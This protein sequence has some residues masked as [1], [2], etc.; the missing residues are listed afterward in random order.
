MQLFYAEG[1]QPTDSIFT[2]SKIESRHITQALRKRVGEKICITNGKGYLF[3]GILE[4][5]MRSEPCRVRI[6]SSKQ[7]PLQAHAMLHIAIA[8]TQSSTRNEWLIEKATELGME[9]LSLVLC[10]YSERKYINLDRMSRIAVAA[11]KQSLQYHLPKL[12]G[13]Q[14]LQSFLEKT[15]EPIKYIATLHDTH[16]IPIHGA[17]SQPQSTCV[18]IGP[19]GGFTK[20]ELIMCQKQG[21]QGLTLTPQRLRTETAALFV[22]SQWA[23]QKT[24]FK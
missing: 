3:E 4:I 15:R 1:L 18:L 16:K 14:D 10:R 23:A 17:F 20:E 7:M 9:K 12:Q 19:E 13:T 6:I 22:V 2:F 24:N 11:M 8:P 21:F 5:T